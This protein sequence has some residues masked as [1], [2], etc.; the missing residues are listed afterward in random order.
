MG[1]P[2]D[3]NEVTSLDAA[4]PHGALLPHGDG[5][6]ADRVRAAT[7]AL[8]AKILADTIAQCGGNKA[9]A[10]R[11]LHIDYTTLHRKMKRHGLPA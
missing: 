5:S 6:L 7:D 11:A 3:A 10:A 4:S 2:S 8:E 1:S 9:A